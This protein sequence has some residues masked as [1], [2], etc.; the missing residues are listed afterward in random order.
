[1][2][3]DDDVEPGLGRGRKRRMRAGAAIDGDRHRDALRLEPQQRRR[4]RAV[5]LALAVGDVEP[6]A[7]ADGGE[8]ALNERRRGRAVDIVVAED[9]DEL[10]VGDRAHQPRH[11]HVHV[12]QMR[13]VGQEVAQGRREE[14]LRRLD[15]DAARGQQPADDLRQVETLRQ[16]QAGAVVRRALAP[17]PARKASA[18]RRERR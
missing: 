2:I 9:G 16:R 1:M 13:R 17:A 6:D 5:A 3:D 12:L 10:A 11:R 7:A 18:R 14:A 8:K 4:V 15:L